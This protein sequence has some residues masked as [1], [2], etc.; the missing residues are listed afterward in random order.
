MP[1]VE[2]TRKEF[3]A[4]GERYLIIE[5][6]GR[7]DIQPA[8]EFVIHNMPLTGTITL[9]QEQLVDGSA[10]FTRPTI[11]TKAGFAADSINEVSEALNPDDN[12]RIGQNRRFSTLVGK[13]YIRSSP[14]VALGASGLIAGRITIQI[15][16]AAG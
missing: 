3:R 6:R 4:S 9:F 15:G 5:Y 1:Y 14:N 8:E 2:I 11:G 7:G 12:H 13:L 10:S 16:H